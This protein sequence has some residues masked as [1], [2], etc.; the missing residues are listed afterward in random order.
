MSLS[1]LDVLKC[2]SEG[3]QSASL[4][5]C[6]VPTCKNN[7]IPELILTLGHVFLAV[8]WHCLQIFIYFEYIL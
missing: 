5:F 7:H 8:P 6:E 3:M 4:H 1:L 2:G